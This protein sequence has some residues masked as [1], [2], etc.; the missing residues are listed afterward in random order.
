M[1]LKWSKIYQWLSLSCLGLI[2]ANLVNCTNH[3]FQS[4][5]VIKHDVKNEP[6][7]T[8]I[9]AKY[10]F[11]Y[12]NQQQITLHK[13]S[14]EDQYW[15]VVQPSTPLNFPS[16]SKLAIHQSFEI[17]F[18]Q[19][20]T[21][22][23]L[24]PSFE[25]SIFNDKVVH[26]KNL[27]I[28]L[29]GF[30][31]ISFNGLN[32]KTWTDDLQVTNIILS[33]SLTSLNRDAIANNPYLTSLTLSHNL[34]AS[35]IAIGAFNNLSHLTKDQVNLNENSN[36]KFYSIADK[37]Q[38]FALVE[39][40][41]NY[42]TNDTKPIG[43]MVFGILDFNWINNS[44]NTAKVT[45]IADSAFSGAT[46]LQSIILDENITTIG[47][48]AFRDNPNLTTVDFLNSKLE[49][50]GDYAFNKCVNID[51]LSI[52]KTLTTI[53]N[54]TFGKELNDQ[55]KLQTI[56]FYWT[57][58]EIEKL[59]LNWD[60]NA[61]KGHTYNKIH[62]VINLES[63]FYLAENEKIGDIYATKLFKNVFQ[64]FKIEVKNLNSTISVGLIV[65]IS[66]A[67]VLVLGL[68]TLAIINIV[69]H[70]KKKK[71]LNNQ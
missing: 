52:P 51:T 1:K 3:Q 17:H 34:E 41:L 66:L 57:I 19:T 15:T 37:N 42:W 2:G 10:L 50:I 61:F 32:A 64:S 49:Q 45:S 65:G 59:N 24:D 71:Q 69:R 26:G 5:H 28:T 4:V 36:L 33:N 8:T 9:D 20:V 40:T 48:S 11:G 7:N 12:D 62:L 39:K 70:N 56:N 30:T 38:G 63:N 54:E 47:T 16:G 68:G 35:K 21:T 14:N 46:N 13:D 60:K 27:S 43:S 29:D 25:Q 23:T 55:T 67:T 31:G 44:V 18:A 6:I 53:G 22:F 58:E